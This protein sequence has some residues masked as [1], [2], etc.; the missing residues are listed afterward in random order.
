MPRNLSKQILFSIENRGVVAGHIGP[1]HKT[2]LARLYGLAHPQVVAS[3][4]FWLR[5]SPHEPAAERRTP[6]EDYSAK[7]GV[8][9]R[10]AGLA[11]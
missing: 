1:R 7:Q 4:A 6:P 11:W 3:T 5:S 2:G 9:K 10:A 8:P